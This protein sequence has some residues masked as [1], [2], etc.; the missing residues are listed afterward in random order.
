[1]TLCRLLSGHVGFGKIMTHEDF[2]ILNSAKEALAFAIL[3]H[4]TLLGEPNNVPNATGAA[5]RLVLGSI[6]PA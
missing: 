2:G 4:A 1:M 5:R 6:V 3:A